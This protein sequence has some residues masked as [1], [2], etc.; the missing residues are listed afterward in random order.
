M[1]DLLVPID[2]AGPVVLPKQVREELSINPGD[3]LQVTVQ[4]DQVTLRPNRQ[5]AGFIRRGKALIFS[6]RG[7]EVPDNQ[8]IEALLAEDRSGTINEFVEGLPRQK[9]K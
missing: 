8:V 7:A 9:C 1:R 6:T 3:L 4:G 2:M 5:K